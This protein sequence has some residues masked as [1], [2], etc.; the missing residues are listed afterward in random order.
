MEISIERMDSA[1]V[2]DFY[3]IHHPDHE[4]GWCYCVA[5]WVETWEGW[6]E[7]RDQE[8]RRLRDRLFREGQYDGYLLYIDGVPAGWCQCGPRDRLDKLVIQY[9]LAPDPDTWAITCFVILPE[10]RGSG[11]THRFLAGV[12]RDL[13]MRDVQHVQGFPRRQVKFSAGEA[14]TGP[15]A[16]FKRGGFVVE[17]DHPERPVYGK[18]LG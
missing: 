7:R 17:I 13:E 14:W 18:R 2:N 8:N 3:R 15:E 5:W 4:T 1:R 10:Y 9:G 6:G 16:V 11:L 12:L